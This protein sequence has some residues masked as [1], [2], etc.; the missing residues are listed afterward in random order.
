MLIS[1][2]VHG[3]LKYYRVAGYFGKLKVS[4]SHQQKFYKEKIGIIFFEEKYH[5]PGLKKV[6]R[7][8]TIS[9]TGCGEIRTKEKKIFFNSN[10][11][12]G[13]ILGFSG[14]QVN[15]KSF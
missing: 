15:S 3:N 9:T 2:K 14:K 6:K 13:E 7:L 12:T 10:I 8:H 5:F 1:P 11:N 4:S